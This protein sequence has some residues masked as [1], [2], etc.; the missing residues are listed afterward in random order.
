MEEYS[1]VFYYK[2]I[3]VKNQYRKEVASFHI[4]FFPGKWG[5]CPEFWNGGGVTFRM[6]FRA[7]V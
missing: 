6:G 7:G 4:L 5:F 2:C 3:D 1:E